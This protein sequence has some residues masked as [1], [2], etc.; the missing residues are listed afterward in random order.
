MQGCLLCVLLTE[1]DADE[2]VRDQRPRHGVHAGGTRH[3]RGIRGT[4]LR[5]VSQLNV[6]VGLCWVSRSVGQMFHHSYFKNFD[7]RKVYRPY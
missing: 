6:S 7:R 1:R 5:R 4:E 3:P 2:A